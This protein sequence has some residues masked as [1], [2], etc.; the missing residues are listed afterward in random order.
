M[1]LLAGQE[2]CAGSVSR[3]QSRRWEGE[4]TTKT[5][6]LLGRAHGRALLALPLALVAAGGLLGGRGSVAAPAPRSFP[7]AGQWT[8]GTPDLVIATPVTT[9]RARGSDWYGDLGGVATGLTEDR[10]IRAVEVREYRPKEERF[11]RAA[12]TTDGGGD[13]NLF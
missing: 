3:N 8:L 7:P 4:M 9:V 12:G 1:R 13:F 5:S 6:R 11:R 10:W 2:A